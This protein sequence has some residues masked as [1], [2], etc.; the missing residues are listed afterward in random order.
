VRRIIY[1]YFFLTKYTVVLV[2]VDLLNA[3]FT[4][5][6]LFLGLKSHDDCVLTYG[7]LHGVVSSCDLAEC[8]SVSRD[9]RKDVCVY[10]CHIHLHT[11]SGLVYLS[12]SHFSIIF[13]P[14]VLFYF[15]SH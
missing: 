4:N 2:K 6:M 10:I 15:F 9:R 14:P 3:S 7:Q 11:L 13:L 5:G 1:I 8:K 12:L